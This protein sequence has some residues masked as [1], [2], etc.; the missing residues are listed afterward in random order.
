[1]TANEVRRRLTQYYSE[2]EQLPAFRIELPAGSYIPQ[3]GGFPGLVL[4][5]PNE[6]SP[7][8]GTNDSNGAS[9]AILL[10]SRHS[11]HPRSRN[12]LLWFIVAC[13][14]WIV[15]VVSA[16]SIP[17]A[18]AQTGDRY[19]FY[20]DL[21]GPVATD[22]GRET[23]IVLSNPSQDYTGLGEAVSAFNVGRLMDRI[24]RPI[25]LTEARFLNWGAAR[26]VHLIL[27][28][29]PQ[30]SSWVQE[31]SPPSNFTM[32]HDAITNARPLPGELKAY[33]P[34]GAGNVL[35]DYGLIWMARSA[36]GSR[37]LL[38]AGLTSVGTA[39]VGDFFC[40]PDRM[41]P[42]CTHLRAATKNGSIPSD[43]QVLLHIH[44]RDNVPLEVSL[45]S[46]R[47]N[48]TKP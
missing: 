35:D 47:A 12:A 29:A 42:V 21:L 27:L 17:T 30:V 15:G 46:L 45:V 18:R 38:M 39:G 44:A 11:T 24:D 19:E 9:P 2:R 31:C 40:D 41:R 6:K 28:G 5:I 13:L 10:A 25:R 33:R 8:A 3:F 36:A 23:E 22:G 7:R 48:S 16:R 43:W 1:M 14:S 34:S 37:Q 26:N 32:E 4:P 20:R